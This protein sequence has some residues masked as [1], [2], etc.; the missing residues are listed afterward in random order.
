MSWCSSSQ[1]PQAL[2]AI[3]STP[4]RLGTMVLGLSSAEHAESQDLTLSGQNWVAQGV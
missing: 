2:C 1:V 3:A 4:W